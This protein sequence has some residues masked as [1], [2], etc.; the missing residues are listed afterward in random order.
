MLIVLGVYRRQYHHLGFGGCQV[1]VQ[2]V[3]YLASR[4]AHA[5]QLHLSNMS[6]QPPA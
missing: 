6:L 2:G 1:G 3:A 4:V 5:R